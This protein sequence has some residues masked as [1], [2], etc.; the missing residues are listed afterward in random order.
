[1][2][3]FG[4][5]EKVLKSSK[6][7]F[8]FTICCNY[9]KISVPQWKAP[10]EPLKRLLNR[11]SP[12][13]KEFLNNIRGYNTS[14]AFESLGAQIDELINVS[15]IYNFKIHG[16]VYHR[17]GSLLP[18]NNDGPK[19]AQIYFHDTEN[20]LNN[21]LK[22]T[23]NLDPNIL[24]SLQHMMHQHNQFYLE[25]KLLLNNGQLNVPNINLIIKEDAGA[26]KRRYNA[27]TAT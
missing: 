19:F 6:T 21:R 10:P 9:G 4:K 5:N 24:M 12:D 23:S 11:E 27:P 15:G 22:Y 18:S 16:S 3:I 13:S 20:E 7:K 26:D 2:L 17:I 8:I 25:F 14:L 1:M